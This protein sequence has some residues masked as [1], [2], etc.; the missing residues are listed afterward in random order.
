LFIPSEI[1]LFSPKFITNILRDE[2]QSQEFL[3]YTADYLK[4]DQKSIRRT[5]IKMLKEKDH[6]NKDIMKLVNPSIFDFFAGKDDLAVRGDF[7]L[8]F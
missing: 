1:E 6:K 5:I 2:H 7:F 3:A 8:Y 4:L